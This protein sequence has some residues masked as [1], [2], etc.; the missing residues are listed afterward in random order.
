MIRVLHVYKLFG[1]G[2]AQG[3]TMG[4]FDSI[5]REKINFDFILH[6]DDTCAFEEEARA[7]GANIYRLPP[8][9]GFNLFGY[10]KAWK[11]FLA[12][13]DGYDAVH[14][15]VTNFAFAF[16]ALLKNIPMRIAHAHNASDSSILK[17]IAVKLTRKYIL[18]HATHFLAASQMASDFTFGKGAKDVIV[19]PNPIDVPAFTY[20]PAAR[21]RMREELGLG[22]SLTVGH[23]GRFYEQKNH[24]YLFQVA[25]ELQRECPEAV[26][27]LVGDGPLFEEL[28]GQADEMGI[29]ARFLGVRKD[30]P[31]LMQ[32]MDVLAMPSLFEGLC[33]AVVEALS[34]GLPCV[35][36]DRFPGECE[37]VPSLVTFLPIEPSS[38][39]GWVRAILGARG[40]VREDTCDRIC[41]FGFDVKTQARRELEFYERGA[42]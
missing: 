24:P 26:L 5:D 30:I 16:L 36:S 1:R 7:L 39:G 37:L 31:E 20:D 4:I 35:L 8:F 18:R 23:V 12:K 21:L 29:N 2:G 40:N 33:N 13:S 9:K 42:C 27:L 3:R 38:V 14:I 19:A 32:A 6:T 11:D 28:K 25:K 22:E 17:R 41:A 10:R 34:S 15:H